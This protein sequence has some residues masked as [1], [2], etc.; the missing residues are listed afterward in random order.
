MN[1]FSYVVGFLILTA[2]IGAGYFYTVK[3][4]EAPSNINDTS[5]E[6]EDAGIDTDLYPTTP[7]EDSSGGTAGSGGAGAGATDT[8]VE[9]MAKVIVKYSKNGYFPSSID[10]K[11]GQTVRWESD[12]SPMWTASAMHPTHEIY[13]EFDQKATGN[14]YEFTFTKA[15]SWKYHNHVS[16][17]H[18]GT[19]NVK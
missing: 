2:I 7:G 6:G 16:A 12:G 1:V 14:V 8:S 17:N 18:F 19:V 11:L 9:P 3:P 4:S 13:P 5:L 10:V 15:G